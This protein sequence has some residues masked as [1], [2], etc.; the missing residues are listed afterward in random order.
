MSAEPTGPEQ[1]ADPAALLLEQALKIVTGARRAAYGTPEDNFTCIANLWMDYLQRRAAT[2]CGKGSRD[3]VTITAGDVAAMMILMKAARLAETP[4]HAD[5]WRDIAGY[6]ACGA[7]ASGAD[8][9]K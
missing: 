3:L 2:V 9:T 8:L 1:P 4:N 6:A 5:S 7:R